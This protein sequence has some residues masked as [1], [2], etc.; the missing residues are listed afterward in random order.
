[1]DYIHNIFTN[2]LNNT[3]KWGVQLMHMKLALV[4]RLHVTNLATALAPSA[5]HSQLLRSFEHA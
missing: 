2:N 3:K 5:T 1:M 4:Q